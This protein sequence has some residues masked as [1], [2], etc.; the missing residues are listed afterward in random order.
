VCA[1]LEQ[2]PA[3]LVVLDIYP[4]AAASSSALYEDDG[5]TYAY[6][7]GACAVTEFT[8]QQMDDA[9][10]IAIGPRTGDY[11]GISAART[12][13]LS[14]HTAAL[15]AQVRRDGVALAEHLRREALLGDGAARGWWYDAARRVTWVKPDAGWRF[16]AD[17]RGAADPEQDTLVWTTEA[18]PSGAA[19]ELVLRLSASPRHQLIPNSRSL[20]PDPCP[21]PPDRL[22]VVANPPERIALKWGD[23]L[24]HKTNLYVSI[25]AGERP[26]PTA[27]GTVRMEVMDASGE[28]IR[29]AEQAAQ[30]GRVEFLGEEYV[31]GETVFRFTCAELQPCEVSIRPAPS[32]PGHMFGPAAG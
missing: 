2:E 16:D 22:R 23:W 4:A 19:C 8:C 1:Y 27:T 9:V 24:P 14:L 10:R 30:R 15:P 11:A 18:R 6:E 5:R 3:D 17:G 26:A 25:C 12:Y 29:Q 7:E 20:T 31:P 28:V 13:L 21:P 32:V